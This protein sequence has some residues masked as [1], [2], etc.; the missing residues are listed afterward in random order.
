[1]NWSQDFP[2]SSKT[3]LRAYWKFLLLKF[4]FS[5]LANSNNIIIICFATSVK[6]KNF[7]R[8]GGFL[9][10]T[11]S[12]I[13]TSERNVTIINLNQTRLHCACMAAYNRDYSLILSVYL[14]SNTR[15]TKRRDL[16]RLLR[17]SLKCGRTFCI[18]EGP[19]YRP[20]H[21]LRS[22]PKA[23]RSREQVENHGRACTQVLF[24]T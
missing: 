20:F 17:F 18:G 11:I 14:A 3:E 19:E 13:S 9:V 6:E 16:A 21:D 4:L 12:N 22:V 23:D 10:L 8:I 24:L 15:P 7:T 5:P 1:M 2:D